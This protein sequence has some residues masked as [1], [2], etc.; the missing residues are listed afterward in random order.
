MTDQLLTDEKI[1][2][3]RAEHAFRTVPRHEFV[4]AG[5][6]LETAYDAY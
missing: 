1:T 2:S 3:P 6:T 5:T 4:P